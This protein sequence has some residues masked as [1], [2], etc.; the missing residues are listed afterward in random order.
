M[1]DYWRFMV[2]LYVCNSENNFKMSLVKDSAKNDPYLWGRG[3]QIVSIGAYC[4][5]PNHFHLLITEKESGGIS[6]FIQK[7]STAYV[8]YHNIKYERTGVLF[9]GKF[10][11]EHL[12]T[13]QYLK[14][15]FSYV[16]LNP[17]KLIQKD[18]K[19]AGIKNK[20]VALNYLDNYKYSSY[21]DF[22]GVE[23]KEGAILDR[24]AYPDYFPSTKTFEREILDWVN[25]KDQVE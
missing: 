16:H 18:W 7:L 19:E 9:E 2:L 17:L 5:M 12:D 1:E 11:S 24:Q 4:L 21:L 15:I 3:S 6:K 14:Y 22:E 25:Y 20:K 23:R 10:K 13:D 8:M